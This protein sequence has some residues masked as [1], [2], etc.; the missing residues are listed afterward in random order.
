MKIRKILQVDKQN[1]NDALSEYGVEDSKNPKKH[2]KILTA[3]DLFFDRC[4]FIAIDRN[5]IN[6]SQR[7]ELSE[8]LISQIKT[9]I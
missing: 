8:L 4:L 5:I 2:E 6:D 3:F 1:I 9:K 7:D